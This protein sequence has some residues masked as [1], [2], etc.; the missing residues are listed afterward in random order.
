MDIAAIPKVELHCHLEGTLSARMVRA[1][2]RDLPDFPVRPE[3]FDGV[4]VHDYDSFWAWWPV[5]QP[6]RRQPRYFYPVL[7]Q[8][9]ADLKA[10]NVR[11]TEIM[12]GAGDIPSDT[13]EALDTM[14]ALREQINQLE[15]GVI[16]VEF[17]AACGRHNPPEHFAGREARMIALHEAGLLSGIAIGAAEPGNPVQ[18]FSK[19]LQAWS[20]AGLGIEVHAGEWVGPESV[21]DALNFGFPDRIGHGVTLFDDPKLVEIF[22]ERQIHIEMCPTSNLKTGSVQRIEDHPIR[23]ALDLGLNIGINTDDPGPFACDMNSEYALL[24]ETFD[25]TEAD[26]KTIY[27]NSLAAR[28]EPT[29]RIPG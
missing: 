7:K 23:R 26:F 11:Y 28:F 18:P 25:L 29:L 14:A 10:Q 21:W 2:R 5:I 19:T 24:A 16:Q 8:H 4:T 13:A 22:Q 9:I 15:E 6:M 17:L 1:I 12:F 3:D 20:E 27:D